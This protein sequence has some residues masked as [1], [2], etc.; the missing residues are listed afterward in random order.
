MGFH[1]VWRYQLPRSS[2]AW[3]HLQNLQ[4][5]PSAL[6]A[7]RLGKML[8]LFH[9]RQHY[10]K[11]PLFYVIAKGFSVDTP[12][13]AA[14]FSAAVFSI[15]PLLVY[16]LARVTF[17]E[18]E[19]LLAGLIVAV[20]SAFVYTM[21]FFSGGEPLAVALLLLGLWIHTRYRPLASVPIYVAIVFLH[22]LTSL[23][24]W[25]FLLIL[26]I[27]SRPPSRKEVLETAGTIL[28][29]SAAFLSWMLFQILAGLP[30]GYFVT[31]KLSTGIMLGL[32]VSITGGFV[33]AILLQE[34]IPTLYALFDKMK[35]WV[36]RYLTH[37]ILLLEAI[38]LV[39]L[40][41]V[42]MPGTE[43]DITPLV[44]AFYLPL[45]GAVALGGL[46]G[47]EL[48]PMTA[49]LVSASL[50]LIIAGVLLLPRGVPV[51]R[52]APYCAIALG[53]L[54]VPV[55][56]RPRM[57]LALPLVIAGLAATVYPTASF[58]FGFD[59]QYY[60]PEAAALDKIGNA[61]LGG[62]VMTDVRMEDF[63]AYSSHRELLIPPEGPVTLRAR[64]MAL[65]NP[66]MRDEGFYPPGAQWFRDP[67]KLD[68][69]IIDSA[70]TKTYH[71]GWVELYHVPEEGL[72]ISEVVS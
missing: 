63:V 65:V 14:V 42:G 49:A 31:T 25:I 54:V 32:Y 11:Y 22:P 68:L 45:L 69:S 15:L 55:I 20:T 67:F 29:F 48:E 57:R 4:A 47:C 34:R 62:R 50:V 38:F 61:T 2:E 9:N 40:L 72:E 37:L 66:L 53:F 7:A 19:A 71:N 23:F 35:S 30:L 52:L 59:E 33:I 21:N 51:Y 1:P 27:L 3:S 16:L 28:V 5:I 70:S 10:T 36:R 26:P 58:Y 64:D 8:D 13:K 41:T 24:A 12:W 43:Q 46:R 6:D 44:A 56:R 17:N 18:L 60:P 39:L